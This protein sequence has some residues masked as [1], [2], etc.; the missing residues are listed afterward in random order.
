MGARGSRKRTRFVRKL[1]TA[2]CL[3][4][5]GASAAHATPI[6]ESTDFGNSFAARTLLPPGTYAVDGHVGF[7]DD[8]DFFQL[9]GLTPLAPFT[10]H[11]ATA[12]G[13]FIGGEVRTS[14]DASLGIGGFDVNM[15]FDVSGSVPA[16]GILVL[17]TFFQ[18]GGPY[19][20]SVVPEPATTTLLA[21]G[22]VGLAARRRNGAR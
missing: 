11:F 17:R 22:L 7:G 8:D 9:S 14:A 15:P 1:L 4:A 21:A 18:E 3:G 19:Q 16:D 10:V 13:P 12:Q 6:T 2:T 5:A 20:V